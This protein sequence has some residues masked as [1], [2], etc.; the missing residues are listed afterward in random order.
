MVPKGENQVLATKGKAEGKAKRQGI[1]LG[2]D[3]GGHTWKTQLTG[4]Q[5]ING[6]DFV[7]PNN[8]WALTDNSLLRTVDGGKKWGQ[9]SEPTS[10][11]TA[12]QF[13]NTNHGFGIT[14]DGSLVVTTDGGSTWTEIGHK[15]SNIE[16]FCFTD[17]ATGFAV[18]DTG[19]VKTSDGGKSWQLS[20][21]V[22]LNWGAF[23][24]AIQCQG[25]SGWALFHLT[26]GTSSRPTIVVHTVDYGGHW[27][28]VM[29]DATRP[30]PTLPVS[31]VGPNAGPFSVLGK[32]A[33]YFVGECMICNGPDGGLGTLTITGTND[34]GGTSNTVAVPGGGLDAIGIAF[35]DSNTGWLQVAV[36][37]DSPTPENQY[38]S[39]YKNEV[40]QTVD[41]AQTWNIIYGGDTQDKSG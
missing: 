11:L 7:D 14:L 41:G 9:V 1:I 25:D 4:P 37:V 2:T 36:T 17:D 34:A 24:N 15:P 23:G 6:L 28:P 38:K 26:P 32:E 13:T 29:L 21:Q 3:D 33:G 39:T 30:Q 40:L 16:S 12:V 27:L 31:T 10:P 22:P 5:M 35:S 8:G 18:S 19:I 20:F